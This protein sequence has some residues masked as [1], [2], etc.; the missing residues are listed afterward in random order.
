MK[1]VGAQH[2]DKTED[3]DVYLLTEDEVRELLNQ[4]DMKQAL[5]VAP[6]WK[7]FYMKK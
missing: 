3:L 2:F 4:G 5:M 6:L 1:P 7:Y